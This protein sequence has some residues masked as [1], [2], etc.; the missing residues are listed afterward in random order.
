MRQHAKPAFTL[1]MATVA[2][3][4]LSQSAAAQFSSS[5]RTGS[6]SGNALT[7]GTTNTQAAAAGGTS[8]LGGANR[9]GGNAQ[10]LSQNSRT[11]GT[12]AADLGQSTLNQGN[13]NAFIGGRN[14]AQGQGGFI[15]ANQRTGQQQNNRQQQSNRQNN[16]GQ[17]DFNNQNGQGQNQ[18]PKR[19]I[20]PQFKVAFDEMP[21]PTTAEVR[22]TLQPR[23]DSLSQTPSLRGVAYEL[24][25]EGVVVLRGTVDTPSQ[26]RLAENVV[27]LEPGVKK[28]RN[29]LMLN[30]K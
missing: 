16:F 17:N 27:K 18:D 1:L 2:C 26:R 9:A 10:G 4:L 19:A 24:D 13:Q 5:T 11:A 20:R 15:G 22:S 6:S 7:S 14:P 8:A 21:R 30:E 12:G 28:V 3:G 29:E 23:F 25:T